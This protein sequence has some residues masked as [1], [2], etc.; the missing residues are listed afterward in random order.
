MSEKTS[1]RTTGG[2]ILAFAVLPDGDN[3]FTPCPEILTEEE[4]IR[5][6]RLDIRGPQ[7]P[8]NTLQYY[9]DRGVLHGVRIGRQMRYPRREL[10]AMVERL[11]EGST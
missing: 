6:L 9:R 4:A 7:N 3:G 1:N 11:L 8:K 10:D 2:Q 5:Y